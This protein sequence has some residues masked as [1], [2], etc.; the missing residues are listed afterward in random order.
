[1]DGIH[2]ETWN[3][4]HSV[5]ITQIDD[6]SKFSVSLWDLKGA[7]EGAGRSVDE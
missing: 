2:L 3:L 5:E 4:Q 1:M 6:G 7:A